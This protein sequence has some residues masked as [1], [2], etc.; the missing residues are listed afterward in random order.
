MCLPCFAER[1]IRKSVSAQPR[2]C[3]HAHFSLH[4]PTHY[5][6]GPAQI[7][8]V[9]G[10]RGDADASEASSSGDD[11]DEEEYKCCACQSLTW[12]IRC[13]VPT[14]LVVLLFLAMAVWELTVAICD[15]CF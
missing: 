3:S 14:L 4:H 7:A 12:K 6:R 10:P 11:E 9:P 2:I 8:A 13:P 1:K 5:I 15:L